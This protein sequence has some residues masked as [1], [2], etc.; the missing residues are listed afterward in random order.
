M[1]FLEY[2]H[3]SRYLSIRFSFSQE[4]MARS[5]TYID[6]CS[7]TGVSNLPSP[8][9]LLILSKTRSSIDLCEEVVSQ[10]MIHGRELG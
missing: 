3:P 5:T 9:A 1:L 7:G 6:A 8:T 4:R 2:R 10:I